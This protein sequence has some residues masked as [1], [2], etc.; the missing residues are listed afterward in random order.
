MS[1]NNIFPLEPWAEL[2]LKIIFY[3]VDARVQLIDLAIHDNINCPAY[4][5]SAHHRKYYSWP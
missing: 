2:L 4:L 3:T 1:G 5:G